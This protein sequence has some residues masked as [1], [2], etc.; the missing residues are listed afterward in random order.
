MNGIN[1][2]T[3]KI[4]GCAIEVHRHLEP[5]L[6]EQTYETA[7]CIEFELSGLKYQR[8]MTFPLVYKGSPIGEH[9]VDLLVEDT[10]RD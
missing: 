7:L 10:V 4:I 3:E 1:E 8:Q 5:G 6:L 9:R 2:L